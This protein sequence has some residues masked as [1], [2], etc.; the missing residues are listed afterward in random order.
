MN[1]NVG[2][3]A[4]EHTEWVWQSPHSVAVPLHG[5]IISEKDHLNQSSMTTCRWSCCWLHSIMWSWWW[6]T[7]KLMRSCLR[8]HASYS[9]KITKIQTPLVW[10][11]WLFYNTYVSC[12]AIFI[13]FGFMVILCTPLN[14]VV[15]VAGY[16][17]IDEKLFTLKVLAAPYTAILSCDRI[18]LNRHVILHYTIPKP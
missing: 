15:M 14:H 18:L 6:F 3:G 9:T 11:A 13:L 2:I 7:A 12:S 16:R 17:W 5:L 1:Y 8:L 10:F 4:Q